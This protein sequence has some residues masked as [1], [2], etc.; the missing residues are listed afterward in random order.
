MHVFDL[1]VA[2]GELHAECLREPVAEVMARAGLQRL[3]VV[4]QGF[5]RIGRFRAGEFFLF[6]LASADDRDRQDLFAEI[7]VDVQHLLCPCRSFL[8]RG[9]RGMAFLPQEFARAQERARRLFPADDRAPLVVKPR[10][11]TVGMDILRIEVAEQRLGGRTYA[12]LLLQ[13][14]K[15]ALCDP[16]HFRREALY[17]VF[18]LLQKRFRN[19]HGQVY[20]FHA[21]LLEPSVKL[22]P[23]VLPDRVPGRLDDHTALHGRIAGQL[24]LFDH[25]GIP[26]REIHIARRDRLYHFLFVCHGF[27]APVFIMPRILRASFSTVPVPPCV[28]SSYT[29]STGRRPR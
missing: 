4:H 7:R 10:Q 24:R 5:D 16:G 27:F 20:V 9:V 2:V 14:R 11:I 12:H 3:P 25:V 23:D 26:L 22:V 6:G 21:R 8:G 18:F 13:R 28:R 1:V 19:E 15:T 29:G 17:V